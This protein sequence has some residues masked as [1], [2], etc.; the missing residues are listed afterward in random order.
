MKK[1]QY[2]APVTVLHI[3]EVDAIMIGNNSATAAPPPLT[4]ATEAD[5]DGDD[6]N[7]SRRHLNYW[8]E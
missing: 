7:A 6:P 1:K 8:D 2:I 4:I 5:P 3:E